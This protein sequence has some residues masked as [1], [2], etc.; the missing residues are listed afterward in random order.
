MLIS[1]RP[2]L[3]QDFDY[4]RRLYF[5]EMDWIIQELHLDRASQ[6][7]GFDKP[8]SLAQVRIITLDGADIAWLQ[9]FTQENEF[10]VAQL[11]VDRPFQRRG[12]VRR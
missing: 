5:C 9:T 3:K 8:W 4:C 2:A 10:F 6:A 11:F 7:A 1:L 12:S